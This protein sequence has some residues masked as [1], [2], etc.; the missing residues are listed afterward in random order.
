MLDKVEAAVIGSFIGDALALGVHWVYDPQKIIDAYGRVDR[1][2]DPR[3]VGYHAGKK[4]GDFTH[5]GDQTFE[6]LISVSTSGAFDALNYMSR[7]RALFHGDPGIYRDEATRKTL[8]EFDKC[9]TYSGCLSRSRDLGGAAR[10]APLLIVYHDDV[11][12]LRREAMEQTQLTHNNETVM[13][14]AAFFA[15]TAFRVIGGQT[16]IGAMEAALNEG[17][18]RYDHI[19]Q[20]VRDGLKSRE[21]DRETLFAR[22]G[23]G[24]GIQEALPGTVYLIAKCDGSFSEALVENVMA[25]GDS[26]SRGLLIGMIMGARLGMNGIPS[27]WLDALRRKDELLGFVHQTSHIHYY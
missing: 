4:G 26:A 14:S 7:W 17:G 13:Q 2:L 20:L 18:A 16:P 1:M 19:G 23:R 5:Y 22:T 27:S 21:L 6:L 9:E 11:D 24:C 15:E 25:G 12:A 10:I 3:L 8:D